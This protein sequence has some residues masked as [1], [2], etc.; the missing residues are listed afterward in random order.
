MCINILSTVPVHGGGGHDTYCLFRYI[1]VILPS[2]RISIKH[3][4][5]KPCLLF[6]IAHQLVMS[7][8]FCSH[9]TPTQKH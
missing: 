1:L 2:Q 5:N 3:V 6:Y 9:P 8:V 4:A 7:V